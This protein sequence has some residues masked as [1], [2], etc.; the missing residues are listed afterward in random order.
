MQRLLPFGNSGTKNGRTEG[1]YGNR[2]AVFVGTRG[3]I[4]DQKCKR[5]GLMG[6]VRMHQR[7]RGQDGE[8]K[9]TSKSNKVLNFPGKKNGMISKGTERKDQSQ[10]DEK[11]KGTGEAREVSKNGFTLGRASCKH[12][13]CSSLEKTRK[14]GAK[15]PLGHLSE[16][17][18]RAGGEGPISLCQQFN[19]RKR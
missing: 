1:R 3:G 12:P 17:S 4:S 7:Q 18:E 16:R 2:E 11:K 8:G 15:E 6:G 10:A 14:V 13:V 9:Q 19:P 5:P